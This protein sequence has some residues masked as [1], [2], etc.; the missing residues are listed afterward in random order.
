ML[1]KPFLIW[2]ILMFTCCKYD[3]S[4]INLTYSEQLQFSHNLYLIAHKKTSLEMKIFLK[5]NWSNS[6][7]K[8]FRQQSL[9]YILEMPCLKVSLAWCKLLHF[10]WL[11]NVRKKSLKV[12][13]NISARYSKKHWVE[14]SIKESVSA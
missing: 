13:W 3:S 7:L 11:N 8:T 10:S 4:V 5:P 14:W 12:S 1:I 2:L 6:Y 9:K